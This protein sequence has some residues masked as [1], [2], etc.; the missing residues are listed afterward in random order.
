MEGK[1][2]IYFRAD[3]G[4]SIG[5][6]HFIR[7][8]ALADMLKDYFDCTFFTQCPT[9]YQIC[10][11]HKICKLEKL[12][13]DNSHFELFLERLS[14]DEIVVLDN[15]FFTTNYQQHIK[16]KGCKLVC[17]DDMH[18][19]H[20][21]ADIVINHGI[22]D[23]SKFDVE[24][25]TQ[26]CLGFNWAL[27]RKPF[28]QPVNKSNKVSGHWLIAF[29]GSD[30]YNLTEKF[31]CLIHDKNIVKH[32]SVVIGDAYQY[33]NNLNKYHKISVRKNLSANDMASLMEKCEYAI[34]P[35]SGIC[36]EALSR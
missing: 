15:Y 1:R 3:A 30:S 28:L 22:T 23:T 4:A 25:Y 36:L 9:T 5:Y 18:D 35:S 11:V 34:L 12:P 29:G 19:K 17:I 2:K 21:I 8:L 7:T 16:D 20:Y 26:L 24:P 31:V 13:A 32:I 10:E 27:L 14:G 6:G 33:T